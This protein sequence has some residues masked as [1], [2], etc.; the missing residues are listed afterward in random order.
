ML[1][2]KFPWKQQHNIDCFVISDIAIYNSNS[3]NIAAKYY[4]VLLYLV[5]CSFLQI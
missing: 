2:I 4:T 5:C 3:S 1:I